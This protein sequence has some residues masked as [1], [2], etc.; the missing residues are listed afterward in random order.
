MSSDQANQPVDTPALDELAAAERYFRH[1]GLVAFC[2]RRH[3]WSTPLQVALVVLATL[4]EGLVL[5]DEPEA[6]VGVAVAVLAVVAAVQ[7]LERHAQ[8]RMFRPLTETAF[9]SAMPLAL[10]LT[11]DMAQ[12]RDLAVVHAA[13]LAA[14]LAEERGGASHLVR[15]S[16][17]FAWS[18]L[19][20]S[21]RS[22][23][24]AVPVLAVVLLSMFLAGETWQIAQAISWYNLAVIV[25]LCTLVGASTAAGVR[26]PVSGLKLAER[27]NVALLS[28]F[29]TGAVAVA[30]AVVFAVFL[31]VV[32]A[33][34]LDATLL[35]A[36]IGTPVA[37][38]KV[39][40]LVTF[41]LSEPLVKVACLVASIAIL[42]FSTALGTDEAYRKIAAEALDD[43]IATAIS[44]R[45]GYLTALAATGTED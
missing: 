45:S 25:V 15:W 35:T 8:R 34:L 9:V 36:W 13:L 7:Q 27:W 41:T 38:F 23:W 1:A 37:H 6:G 16:V 26:T 21:W 33:L 17:R 12:A 43:E 31:A 29:S 18:K 4:V 30:S 5:F 42:V 28:A 39:D 20:R 10:T 14:Y 32:G 24:R 19:R 11:G 40:L 44:R 3:R 2:R 22:L